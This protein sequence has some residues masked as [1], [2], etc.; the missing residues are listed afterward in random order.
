ME[1]FTRW[2]AENHPPKCGAAPSGILMAIKMAGPDG[3]SR[4]ELGNLFDLQPQLLTKLL[5]AFVGVGMVGV[6]RENGEMVFRSVWGSDF[7]VS[8]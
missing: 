7:D 3:I 1:T 2:L 6:A 8:R 4:R 5:V